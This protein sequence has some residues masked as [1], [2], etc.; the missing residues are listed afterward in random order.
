MQ[1]ATNQFLIILFTA[2]FLTYCKTPIE[3]DFSYSPE[4][5]K[6]GE[7]VT[8]TNLTEEGK[9]WNWEFG[10]GGKSR[11]K[12][13]TYTFRE[14]GVYDVRLMVDS[15]KHYVKTKP[16]TI[17][18]TIPTIYIKESVVQYFQEVNFSVLAYNPFNAKITYDWEFSPNAVGED[19][20]NGKTNKAVPKVFYNQTE[21]EETVNL[22]IIVGRDSFE[23]SKTF[24][25][26]DYPA[27]S[28]I[29]AEKNG[30]ILR[31]RMYANG[32]EASLPT[33]YQAGKHPFNIFTKSSQLYVFD[34]GSEVSIE[35]ADV[36]GKAGDG[37]IRKINLETG[38]A[39]EIVH[40]RELGAE[41][42]FYSGLVYGGQ[43]YWTDFNDFVYKTADNNTA[44][45][46]LEWQGDADAQT[47][48][49]YYFLKMD[50]LGYFGNGIASNQLSSG[51]AVYDNIYFLAKGGSGKGVYRFS[52]TDILNENSNGTVDAPAYGSILNEFAIR[53][54]AID[55][56]NAR[57]YFSVTAPEASIGFWVAKLD[58]TAAVRID[59][60]PMGNAIEYITGIAIDDITNKVY[61]SYIAP[62]ALT[63]AQLQENP[64]HRSGVKMVNLAKSNYV[65]TEVVY[66][67]Q[68]VEVLGIA[69]DKV[70]K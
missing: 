69:L 10:D 19:L 44:I 42:G 28:L 63:E 62:E 55:D 29:M 16:I 35:K 32:L 53:S 34:A 17:Y 30:K 1:S 50:R 45:G 4:M 23:V 27:R 67:E 12:G 66:F 54:L 70:K 40:N 20:V 25:V 21:V 36:I 58:G 8:F 5:P 43:I 2:L 61:W 24:F 48:L 26:E 11:L 39:I 60:A 6:A 7:K 68:D 37:S 64:T 38:A 47:T 41:H 22:K 13:P 49:P 31:K 59:D 46:A 14:A 51:L 56:L 3:P 52:T 65:D 9:L 18:D 15:N 33:T 57:I